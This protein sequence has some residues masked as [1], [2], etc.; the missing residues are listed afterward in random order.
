MLV[1]EKLMTVDEF[2]R[3][4]IDRPYELWEGQIVKVSPT[5][6]THGITTI[7][8]GAEVRAFV[9]QHN[10]GEVFGAETGFRLSNISLRAPDVAFV[11]HAKMATVKDLNKFLPFAPDLAVEVISPSERTGKVQTKL[12][13]SIAA[14]TPL[15]WYFYEDRPR[16][17]VYELDK[18]FRVI[19][20]DGTLDGGNVLPG[21]QI[22]VAELF[23]PQ[24][25]VKPDRRKVK[26]KEML[27]AAKWNPD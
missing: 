9:K 23:P 20:L 8:V 13:L 6:G 18:P 16:V 2:E 25:Q 3:L 17:I 15:V 4:Y 7:S 1:Q 10:L 26:A 19:P 22:A 24:I 5:G 21:F 11:G 27:D 12:E 14:R